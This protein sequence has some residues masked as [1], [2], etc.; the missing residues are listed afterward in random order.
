MSQH[1]LGKVMLGHVCF[2]AQKFDLLYEAVVPFF[3]AQ[4]I[5]DLEIRDAVFYATHVFQ[6]P[7]TVLAGFNEIMVSD[8]WTSLYK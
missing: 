2:Y 1:D 6:N 3:F 4:A 8:F 7:K 5:T